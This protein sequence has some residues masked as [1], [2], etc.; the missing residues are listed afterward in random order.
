MDILQGTKY[1]V[2]FV[3]SY[4]KVVMRQALEG[5]DLHSWTQT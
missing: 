2:S 4:M 1:L 5:E 3:I